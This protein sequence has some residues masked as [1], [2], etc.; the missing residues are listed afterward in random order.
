MQDYSNTSDNNPFVDPFYSYPTKTHIGWP[1]IIQ[2]DTKKEPVLIQ[3]PV[4]K[5][6][7][8]F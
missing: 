2:C 1:I 7:N 3:T 4:G 6:Y 5:S 8:W